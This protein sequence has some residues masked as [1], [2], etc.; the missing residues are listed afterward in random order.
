M[1]PFDLDR[2]DLFVRPPFVIAEPPLFLRERHR[3]VP[4]EE[5]NDLRIREP[6]H[7]AP[8]IRR[9]E[10]PEEDPFSAQNPAGFQ[11]ALGTRARR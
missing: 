2:E 8:K 10:W 5:A 3:G 11:H 1:L 9:G 6:F 7:A 4:P